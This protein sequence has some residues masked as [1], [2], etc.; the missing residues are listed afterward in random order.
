MRWPDDFIGKVIQG[1]CLEVMREMPDKCVD[2]V[3]TDFPYGIGEHY[4]HFDDT[5][6]SLKS[7]V[8]AAIPQILRISKIALI[9]PG[10]GNLWKY[11]SPT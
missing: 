7:L 10:V 3:L 11:P 5:Q 8:S 1:D 6:D 4:D 9:T 2:L